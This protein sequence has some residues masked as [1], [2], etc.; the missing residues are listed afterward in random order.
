MSLGCWAYTHP[1][2]AAYIP[3]FLYLELLWRLY[4]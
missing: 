3:L 2:Q 1:G 4:G